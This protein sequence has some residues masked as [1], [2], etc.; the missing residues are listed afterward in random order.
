MTAN[1]ASSSGQAVSGPSD[2][3]PYL[4]LTQ[5]LTGLIHHLVSSGELPHSVL[6][7]DVVNEI[8]LERPKNRDHGDYATSIAL[9]LAKPAGKPPR[10]IAELIAAGL[11]G[12]SNIE[13]VDIAGPGFINLTLVKSSQG[14]IVVSIINE[15]QSFGQVKVLAGKKLILSLLAPIQLAHYILVTPVGQPS[16]MRSE[17][18]WLQV[19]RRL[20]E[21][22]TLMI[23]VLKWICLAPHCELLRAVK[24][25]QKMAIKVST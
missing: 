7:M 24:L 13:S 11:K 5:S 8:V 16:V 23:A 9:A 20:L 2:L 1:S 15:K 18:S 19:A 14:A 3:D 22:F 12:N 21:S 25:D 17:V 10:A 4:A 6:D